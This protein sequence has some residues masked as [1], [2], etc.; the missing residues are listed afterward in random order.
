MIIQISSRKQATRYQVGSWTDGY[1]KQKVQGW[2]AREK[3]KEHNSARGPPPGGGHAAPVKTEAQRGS[4]A[5]VHTYIHQEAN[6]E[7]LKCK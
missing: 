2:N 7:K 6:K 4:L 3:A 1:K 5:V